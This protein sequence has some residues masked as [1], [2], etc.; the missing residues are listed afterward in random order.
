MK[1]CQTG[2]LAVSRACGRIFRNLESK[3]KLKI[4]WDCLDSLMKKTRTRHTD[5]F[6]FSFITLMM[7]YTIRVY[8]GVKTCEVFLCFVAIVRVRVYYG[9]FN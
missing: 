1:D 6:L 4:Y 9:D 8:L 5:Q 3:N 7:C 2:G